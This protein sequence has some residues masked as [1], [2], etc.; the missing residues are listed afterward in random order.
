MSLYPDVLEK[1]HAELDTVVGPGRLP[2]FEDEDSLVY[3]NAIIK[4]TL[5][6]LV[7]LPLGAHSTT[8][9]DE[10]HGYFIPAGTVVIP[11]QWCVQPIPY[12][13]GV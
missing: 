4:E 3:V 12:S 2:D 6:W 10:L 13:A 11:N 9:D 1:A 5:R 8:E 7:V